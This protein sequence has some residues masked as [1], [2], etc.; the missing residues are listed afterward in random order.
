MAAPE[1]KG[2]HKGLQTAE[3]SPGAGTSAPGNLN[4]S[5]GKHKQFQQQPA[6]SPGGQGGSSTTEIGPEGGPPAGEG[7]GNPRAEQA[8]AGP[9]AGETAGPGQQ[10]GG[11]KHQG[12]KQ[13][14]TESPA[15][16]PQ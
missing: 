2:K 3:P 14:V 11:G 5:R 8:P 10:T 16:T 12:K 13:G 1:G 4:E 9:A 15:P 7:R 6:T